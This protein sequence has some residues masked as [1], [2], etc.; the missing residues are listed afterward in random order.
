[1]A[2]GLREAQGM[3]FS[4]TGVFNTCVGFAPTGN[5]L[6]YSFNFQVFVDLRKPDSIGASD[7]ETL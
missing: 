2:F 1:M 7:N 5:L 6:I 3:Y 4:E